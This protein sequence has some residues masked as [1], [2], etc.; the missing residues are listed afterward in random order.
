MKAIGVTAGWV[1]PL[2]GYN[3]NWTKS[4]G[5]QEQ[6]RPT[7]DHYDFVVR[8]QGRTLAKHTKHMGSYENVALG[9]VISAMRQLEQ[10]G[11]KLL[12][13]LDPSTMF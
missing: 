12:P 4:V 8:Y 6:R 11:H 7:S 5:E 9:A 1:D 3:P 10:E 2:D 13:P